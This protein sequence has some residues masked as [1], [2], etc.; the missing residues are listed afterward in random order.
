M[1]CDTS[2]SPTL[3]NGDAHRL[4]TRSINVVSYGR[5]WWVMSSLA[6][7]L[8][9]PCSP[10]RREGLVMAVP[11]RIEALQW[12]SP[13]LVQLSAGSNAQQGTTPGPEGAVTPGGFGVYGS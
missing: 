8:Y 5:S 2:E 10:T 13:G 12:V 4:R 3:N 9:V 7:A 6:E 11:E 1:L